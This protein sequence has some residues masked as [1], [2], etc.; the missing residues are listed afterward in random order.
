MGVYCC[1]VVEFSLYHNVISAGGNINIGVLEQI[2]KLSWDYS[3]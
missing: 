3:K 1:G 2:S